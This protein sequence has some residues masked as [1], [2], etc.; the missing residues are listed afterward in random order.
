MLCKGKEQYQS[1]D[2]TKESQCIVRLSVDTNLCYDETVHF[3]SIII[4]T[5]P[6]SQTMTD[7]ISYHQKA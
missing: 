2:M 6:N 1:G 4:L 7:E 5:L 3:Y